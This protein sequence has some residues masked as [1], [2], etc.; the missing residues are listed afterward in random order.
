MSANCREERLAKYDVPKES[1]NINF[2]GFT[3]IILYT[4]LQGSRN[5]H[6]NGNPKPY[7]T[8]S[9]TPIFRCTGIV[10]NNG[11]VKNK[12]P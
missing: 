2:E 10:M 11:T 6:R 5:Q 12:K 7:P 1:K 4:V 8:E 3:K 9:K